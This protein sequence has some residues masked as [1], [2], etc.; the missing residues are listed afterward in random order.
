MTENSQRRPRRKVPEVAAEGASDNRIVD[1]AVT[2]GDGQVVTLSR[3]TARAAARAVDIAV[4][5]AALIVSVYYSFFAVFQMCAYGGCSSPD[6]SDQRDLRFAAI[7]LLVALAY[8]P[9]TTA[10][11]G[12]TLGKWIIGIRVVTVKTGRRPGLFR[13][14][15]RW[16]PGAAI[17]AVAIVH[18]S[19]RDL[20]AVPVDRRFAYSIEPLPLP[21][22]VLWLGAAL[23]L[24]VHCSSVWSKTRRGWHDKFAGTVVIKAQRGRRVHRFLAPRVAADE[25]PDDLRASEISGE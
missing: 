6:A 14:L 4:M 10:L 22:W 13:A 16:I 9:L 19:V 24:V 11:W 18:E 23:W 25:P 8:E 7:L 2:L 17:V 5:G 12:R 15:V 20:T 3:I 1:Q 21:S